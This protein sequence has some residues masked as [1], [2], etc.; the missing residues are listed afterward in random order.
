MKVFISYSTALDQVVA[1]RL[2]TMAAVYGIASYVPAATTR[3]LSNASLSP[4]VA[5]NLND[6]DV[7]LA[8]ITHAPVPSAITEMNLAVERR[9]LLIPIIGP[10][11]DPGPYRNFK[12]YFVVDPANPSGVEQQI[13]QFLSQQKQAEN[14]KTALLALATLTVALVLFSTLKSDS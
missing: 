3:N 12:P 1:L 6:S 14:T 8:V 5:Q 9:K 2:Q 10:Y 11:V 13:G 7:V 4:E